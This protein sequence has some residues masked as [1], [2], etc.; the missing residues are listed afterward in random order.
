MFVRA[1][2]IG[3]SSSTSSVIVSYTIIEYTDNTFATAKQHEKGIGTLSTT[4]STGITNCTLTRTTLQTTATS[5]NAQPA[6]QN[7]TPAT[8]ISIGTAANTLI[9]IG[10]SAADTFPAVDPYWETS[11]GGGA[12]IGPLCTNVAQNSTSSNFIAV[13]GTE[14]FTPFYWPTTMLV[15]KIW[16]WVNAAYTGGTSNL[17]ARIYAVNSIGR[18]GKLLIDFGAWVFAAQM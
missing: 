1:T 16:T 9:F 12:G 18:P 13:S 10:P 14:Y 8:G 2:G 7:I 15:K 3:L 11:V 4:G 6:T 5:L 17:Y